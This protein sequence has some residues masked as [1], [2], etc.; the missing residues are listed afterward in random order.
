MSIHILASTKDVHESNKSK[1]QGI[2][3]FI[4]LNPAPHKCSEYAQEDRRGLSFETNKKKEQR[5]S[6]EIKNI[7][8]KSY[9][10]ITY[11]F[12]N[13]T[14]KRIWKIQ[15]YTYFTWDIT[16]SYNNF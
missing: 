9:T 5:I 2:N 10:K 16:I 4:C 13:E 6:E 8:E 7:K 11:L 15:I 1:G 12:F 3:V 14:K